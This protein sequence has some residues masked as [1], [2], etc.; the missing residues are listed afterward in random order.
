M[1]LTVNFELILRVYP[2][3]V[4]WPLYIK[5]LDDSDPILVKYNFLNSFKL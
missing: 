1:S 2:T 3:F 4:L 5:L